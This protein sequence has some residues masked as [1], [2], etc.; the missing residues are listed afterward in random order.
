MLPP[1]GGNRV[2]VVTPAGG[3]GVMATDYVEDKSARVKLEMAKLSDETKS[4]IR[5]ASFPFASCSNPVDLTATADD[6]MFAESIDALIDDD[7]VDIVIC[8]TFF[9]PPGITKNLADLVAERVR[10]SPKPIIVFSTYGTFTDSVLKNYYDKGVVG[11]PSILRAVKAAR[12]LVER[13]QI[14]K[15]MEME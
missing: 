6:A 12:Y 2:A 8:I 4:R 7:N 11:F 10:R 1:A 13:A 15:R 3:Y 9:A 14:L 5:N